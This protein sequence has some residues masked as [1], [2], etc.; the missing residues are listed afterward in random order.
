M[1][2]IH[3]CYQCG[4]ELKTVRGLRIH[5]DEVVDWLPRAVEGASKEVRKGNQDFNHSKYGLP[6]L[7]G[8]LQNEV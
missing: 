8:C 3:Q 5:Q 1:A 4:C 2:Y 6:R 7:V